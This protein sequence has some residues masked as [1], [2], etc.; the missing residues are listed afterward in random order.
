M[1]TRVKAGS[2]KSKRHATPS[3]VP[4]SVTSSKNDVKRPRITSS[5]INV[6]QVA[7]NAVVDDDGDSTDG[8][9]VEYNWPTGPFSFKRSKTHEYYGQIHMSK[10]SCERKRIFNVR[11]GG[12]IRVSTETG[13]PLFCHVNR[14][15]SRI[16]SAANDSYRDGDVKVEG[17][18]L[19][20]RTDLI[21]HFRNTITPDSQEHI[22]KLQQ[23]ELVLTN[24]SAALD[25]ADLEGNVR[26]LYLQPDQ[27]LPTDSLPNTYIC[28]FTLDIDSARRTLEWGV[29]SSK[30]LGKPNVDDYEEEIT[31]EFNKDS[32]N[33]SLSLSSMDTDDNSDTAS[34]IEEVPKAM[35][36]E[37][38]GATLR[39][40]IKVGPKFQ[41]VVK[42]FHG[43][44]LV[45]SRQPLL[46]HKSNAIS[47]DELFQFLTRVADVH[48]EYLR[49]NMMTMNDP[50]SPLSQV[51]AEKVMRENPDDV[52][53]TCSSM[54]T[55]SMLAG[56]RCGLMKEC[57]SDAL[58]EILAYHKYDTRLALESVQRNM[59]RIS[60]G[61]T[62]SEKDIFDDAFRRNSG[63]LRKIAKVI[64]PTKTLK[65]VIDYFYRFKVSDQF[66]K[67][68]DKK[69]SIAVR[70]AECIEARKYH[71]SLSSPSNSGVMGTI[72]SSANVETIEK[73]AHWSEK[74][75]A[76]ISVER[77]DRVQS[78]KRLL[79]D[80]KDRLGSKT[81]AEVASVIRQLQECYES[82]GRS[83]LFKLLDGQPELQRRFL[84]FLPKHF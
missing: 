3:L 15:A 71:E 24:S 72:G 4:I 82:D 79:L 17:Y 39:S 31:E 16:K 65:D 19:L 2:R 51:F 25:I 9:V 44:Q 12:T 7:K 42:P 41:A 83:F 56:K 18:W 84:E 34:S 40:E 52:L 78:A 47:D 49:S 21:K 81:M 61:W 58:L 53:L 59:N 70:M 10:L 76:S 68:Q 22:S 37:G 13:K 57:D 64:A 32:R 36:Q 33:R 30:N 23:N 80:V 46:V 74:S 26:V 27:P 62:R 55:S 66:R 50:Y 63:S 69:R 77:D 45:Q 11:H 1:A 60:V 6:P 20:H 67:F 8:T 14:F 29:I 5:K 28:R 38:E 73:S 43:S 48:N 54:S 35:I 75:V